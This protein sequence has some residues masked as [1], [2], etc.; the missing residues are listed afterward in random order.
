MRINRYGYKVCYWNS[1]KKKFVKKFDCNTF[2][3]AEFAATRIE[4]NQEWK[5]VPLRRREARK[6]QR[7]C[8]FNFL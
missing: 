3:L 4:K 8:P 1:D 2:G 5:I 7:K 6:I